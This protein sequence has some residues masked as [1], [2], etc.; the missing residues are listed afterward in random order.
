MSES[1]QKRDSI[2]LFAV[3]FILIVSTVSIL[4]I[5][6]T[7]D[8]IEND[9]KQKL[10]AQLKQTDI[11]IS[12]SGRDAFVQGKVG[13]TDQI[14]LILE[15]LKHIQGVRHLESRI[16]IDPELNQANHL[17]EGET[18]KTNV[19]IMPEVLKGQFSLR[20]DQGKW[21]FNGEIDSP[22][23]EK[24][25]LDAL[26]EMIHSDLVNELTLLNSDTRPSWVNHILQI[27]EPFSLIQGSAE[28]SLNNGLL[29]ISGDINSET[30]KRLVLMSLRES[31]GENT[32]IQNALRILTFDGANYI[33]KTEHEL[34]QLDLSDLQFTTT[35]KQKI[36]V[37]DN[38]QQ[39]LTKIA[40]TLQ[41]TPSLSIEI[42]A[43][44]PDNG[45]I[46][47]D[48]RDSL[49]K[50]MAI[51][52]WLIDRGVSNKQLRTIGYGSERPIA[53]LDDKSNERIEVR[54]IKGG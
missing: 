22:E 13:S 52:K 44:T 7:K 39:S 16:E 20:F 38:D 9:I 29:L 35:D 21:F 4:A 8:S 43:H 41:Q 26:N 23:T 5:F 14:Q 48:R 25:L 17:S 28:L 53:A 3:L 1:L 34:E 42:S 36:V 54:I 33:P 45:D 12:M 2:L 10:D 50:A 47:Q 18:L 27:L 11:T 6:F 51:T 19:I 24:L 31:F 40:E 46:E 37:D 32:Q 30:E 15:P 49:N